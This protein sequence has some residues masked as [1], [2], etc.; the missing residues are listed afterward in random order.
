MRWQTGCERPVALVAQQ[1]PLTVYDE[2]GTIIG[3][4]FADLLI[5]NSLI[6]E[7]KTA[8]ALAP[9]HEAQ[10][11]GYLKSSRLDHALLINFGSYKF[12]IRKFAL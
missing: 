9:E 2:D 1:H 5:E 6:V 3:E 11:I 12:Q 4:Y 10:V 8:K 7:L